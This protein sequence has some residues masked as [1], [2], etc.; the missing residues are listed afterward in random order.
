MTE[1]VY[2]KKLGEREMLVVGDCAIPIDRIRKIDLNAHNGGMSNH[3]SV[4]IITD[5]PEETDLIFVEFADDIKRLM[6]CPY[7]GEEDD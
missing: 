1:R 3:Q 7:L 6:G 4:Q 2:I 5:D